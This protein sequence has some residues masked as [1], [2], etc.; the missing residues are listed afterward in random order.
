[1]MDGSEKGKGQFP[2]RRDRVSCEFVHLY[3]DSSSKTTNSGNDGDKQDW[4]RQGS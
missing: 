1:M 4:S 2:A 3:S